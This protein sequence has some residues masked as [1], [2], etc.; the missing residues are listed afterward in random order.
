MH[1]VV[2]SFPKCFK[3]EE[4]CRVTAVLFSDPL[5]AADLGMTFFPR[6][7]SRLQ[8]WRDAGEASLR[9]RW[10]LEDSGAVP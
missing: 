3:T 2:S 10:K 7:L 5:A 6:N 1:T 4:V 9:A 8:E